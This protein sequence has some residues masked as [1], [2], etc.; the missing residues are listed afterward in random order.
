L[1][2]EKADV[3]SPKPSPA[4][5]AGGSSSSK[6]SGDER[7]YRIVK[8]NPRKEGTHGWNSFN[9]IKDGMTVS[10]YLSK[11]GRKNDLAWDL[12]HKFIELRIK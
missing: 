9:L 8:K 3:K 11:G 5:A 6:F 2:K 12:D 7:I 10:D 4:A 1:K